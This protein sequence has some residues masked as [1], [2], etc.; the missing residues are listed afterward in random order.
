MST[1]HRNRYKDSNER[2]RTGEAVKN[3]PHN[4]ERIRKTTEKLKKLKWFNDGKHELRAKEKP[5]GD[6]WKEGRL[7]LSDSTKKLMSIK[8]KGKQWYTNG[9]KNIKLGKNDIIPEGFYLGV[10]YKNQ[11]GPESGKYHWYNN[12]IKNVYVKECP[13][14]FVPGRIKKI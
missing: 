12:G 5:K 7:F 9:N 13:D 11:I 4:A 14:G 10:T 8:R 6:E 1:I 2:K 3:S